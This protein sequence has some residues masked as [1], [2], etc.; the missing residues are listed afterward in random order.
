MCLTPELTEALL[1]YLKLGDHPQVLSRANELWL[2]AQEL[3]CVRTWHHRLTRQDFETHFEPYSRSSVALQALL[4]TCYHVYLLA[5]SL[6]EKIGQQTQVYLEEKKPLRGYLLD[7]MGSF[8]AETAIKQLDRQLEQH[9]LSCDELVTR[10]FSPGYHD[11]SLDAQR[12][13]MALIGNQLP[14]LCMS[15]NGLLLPEKTITAV[16]GV[17]LQ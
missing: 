3:A 12:I 10:R 8:M 14:G 5:V 2:E 17:F 13:F 9:S 11:F 16:K 6:G 4:G 15:E 1:R 7:R